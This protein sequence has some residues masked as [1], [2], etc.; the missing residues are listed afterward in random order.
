MDWI[1]IA[2]RLH[3]HRRQIDT[4]IDRLA[5]SSEIQNQMQHRIRASVALVERVQLAQLDRHIAAAQEHIRRQ[6]RLVA[7][8]DAKSYELAEA[9]DLLEALTGS[10]GALEWE[11]ILI[12][13]RLR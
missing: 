1:E 6:E 11:R 4:S 2:E 7:R 8:P 9:E 10:L 3:D 13:D 12:L 5:R